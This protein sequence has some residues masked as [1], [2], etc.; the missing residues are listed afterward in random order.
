MKNDVRLNFRQRLAMVQN[1]YEERE[2]RWNRIAQLLDREDFI[3]S[4][5]SSSSSS[6]TSG[7][8]YLNPMPYSTPANGNSNT[9]SS[10]I[11]FDYYIRSFYN[12]D[13]FTLSFLFT[14]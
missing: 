13:N 10:G 4:G 3:G 8:Q 5:S 9:L 1:E 6:A 2:K 14:R 11:Y 7:N 12:N